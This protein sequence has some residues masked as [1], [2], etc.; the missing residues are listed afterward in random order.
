MGMQTHKSGFLD[1]D[2]LSFEN[3]S[4]I[5]EGRADN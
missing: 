2:P 5:I 3:I 4:Y 1:I